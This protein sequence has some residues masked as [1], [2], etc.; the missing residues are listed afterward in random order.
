MYQL[1]GTDAGKQHDITEDTIKECFTN[2]ILAG[3]MNTKGFVLRSLIINKS[4]L[5]FVEFLGQV[6]A[7]D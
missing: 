6:Y 2:L 4:Y 7:L 3:T 5:P 1:S